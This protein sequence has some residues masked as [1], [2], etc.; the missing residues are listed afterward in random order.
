[1]TGVTKMEQPGYF[2]VTGWDINGNSLDIV[3]LKAEYDHAKQSAEYTAQLMRHDPLASKV[4]VEEIQ[5][6]AAAVGGNFSAFLT[7]VSVGLLR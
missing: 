5:E 7:Q 2:R 6:A 4:T 1:M 3:W